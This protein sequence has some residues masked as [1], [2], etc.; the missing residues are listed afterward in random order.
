MALVLP[1][2]I[3][4]D[5]Q[6]PNLPADTSAREI[7]LQPSNGS[8]SYGPSSLI[9]FTLPQRQ[10]LE[11]GSMY[12]R[13]KMVVTGYGSNTTTA[14]TA[15]GIRGIPGY[16]VFQ[17]LEEYAGSQQISNQNE[18]GLVMNDLCNL[19]MSQS[20]KYG[21]QYPLGLT[22]VNVASASDTPLP[23][24]TAQTSLDHASLGDVVSAT[25]R[26]LYLAVP[27]QCALNNCEKLYPLEFSPQY[28]I[29]L[30]TDS[31]SNIIYASSTYV[32]NF[33]YTLSNVE[34]VYNQIEFSNDVINMVASMGGADGKFFVKSQSWAC[35]SVSY[36]G[37]SGSRELTYSHR[38]SSIKSIFSHFSNGTTKSGKFDSIEPAT[39]GGT[40]QFTIDSKPYPER[41]LSTTLNKAGIMMEL[42]RACGGITNKL[43]S[44]S[45][46]TK[47]FSWVDG[48]SPT[49]AEP[50]K[51]IVGC[52]TERLPSQSLLTGVSSNNANTTLRFNGTNSST[53]TAYVYVNYDL[54]FEVDTTM[55]AVTA[56]Y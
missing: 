16:T 51:F 21:L 53:I 47:E 14:D 19:T 39:S 22:Y 42:R 28:M 37:G 34:L 3:G 44:S 26:T 24:D 2:Q 15:A 11:P 41:E 7:V 49:L 29:R 52:N 5:Q 56:R 13:F 10:F 48:N 36:A 50:G 17:K 38:Y 45:I 8:S 18:Y 32:S 1:Q 4:Y 31:V 55:K 27:L 9:E 20:D 25:P 23:T 54:L 35:S 33:S 12:L 40:Y 30:T 43:N 6:L 46:N